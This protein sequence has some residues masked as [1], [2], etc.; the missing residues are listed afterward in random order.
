MAEAPRDRDPNSPKNPPEA[1]LNPTVRRAAVWTF[2]PPLIIF[3]AGAAILLF[4]FRGAPPAEEREAAT[5]PRAEGTTG[6]AAP[7]AETPGGHNPDRVPSSTRDEINQ[8][9][10]RS[11]DELGAVFA[12]GGRTSIGKRVELQEL[13]VERVDSPTLFWVRDGNIRAAVVLPAGHAPLKAG[14]KVNIAGT[15]ERGGDTLQIRASR[16][17]VTP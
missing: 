12:E 14:Q 1:V 16:V 3:F 17:D 15:V 9:A 5:I 7:R 11:L 13:D 2:L 4:Y 6:E 10:G 8:R